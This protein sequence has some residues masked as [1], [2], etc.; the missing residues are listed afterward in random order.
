MGEGGGLVQL[1]GVPPPGVLLPPGVVAE[2]LGESTL[3]EPWHA[4]EA[5]RVVAHSVLALGMAVFRGRVST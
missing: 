1:L 3:G 4:G 5:A 2:A